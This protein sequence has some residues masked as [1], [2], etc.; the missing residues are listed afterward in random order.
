MTSRGERAI[1]VE[2][3]QNNDADV[4]RAISAA[5]KLGVFS[6]AVNAAGVSIPAPHTAAADGTPSPR[7]WVR[8]LQ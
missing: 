2:D 4:A 7:R 5:R 1:A 3:D 6:I 8:F